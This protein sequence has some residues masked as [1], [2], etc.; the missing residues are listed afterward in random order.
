MNWVRIWSICQFFTCHIANA[1][2]VLKRTPAG[3]FSGLVSA[4][5]NEPLI[6]IRVSHFEDEISS[7]YFSSW[8]ALVKLTIHNSKSLKKSFEN[9]EFMK[10]SHFDHFQ[11]W[12][13]GKIN[14]KIPKWNS[15]P[16]IDALISFLPVF[17]KVKEHILCSNVYWS[18]HK[19]QIWKSCWNLPKIY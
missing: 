18:H 14:S 16:W 3:Q 4:W 19:S 12:I 7:Y 1:L 11:L 17:T 15:S 8:L 9:C 5:L 2:L 13:D 10:S 6:V